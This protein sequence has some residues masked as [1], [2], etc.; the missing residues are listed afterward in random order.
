MNTLAMEDS[1]TNAGPATQSLSE[2][3]KTAVRPAIAAGCGAA[4]LMVVGFFGGAS[5][6][7]IAGA[8]VATGAISP[9]GRPQSVQHLDGG[10]VL[11]IRVRNG[12]SVTKDELL[13][14]LDD[15][16]LR[17]AVEIHR[18][19]LHEGLA[20]NARLSA[21]R[22]RAGAID[23]KPAAQFGD[24]EVPVA[25]R[26]SQER[27]F[28]IRRAARSGQSA[29]SGEK[30]KQFLNQKQ[31]V[32]GLLASKL[33]QAESIDLELAKLRRL[34]KEG[35]IAETRLLGLE[36]E[37][38]AL[39]GQV[40]EH[41]AELGRLENGIE[42]A[43]IA[44]LQSDREFQESVLSELRQ[45][46]A[47]VNDVAQQYR[48]TL[49]QLQRVEIRAPAAG[50]VHELA[51]VTVGGV[52]PARATV[53]QLVPQDQEFIVDANLDPQFVDQVVHG[54]SAIVRFPAFSRDTT[55]ELNG[56]VRTVSP[57]SI[58]DERTGVAFYRMEVQLPPAEFARLSG[59]SIVPGMPVEVFVQTGER[60]LVSYLLKP[61]TDQFQRALREK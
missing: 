22:D 35:F 21:E 44:L 33:Q 13:I 59:R 61:L 18:N 36:R 56:T 27:L 47:E 51:V 10:I 43:R 58:V 20:R 11:E 31:G 45:V 7:N 26:A 12:M 15:T 39:A 5:L 19:R 14:R 2:R 55:P 52:V 37:R 25:L 32:Q 9:S 48:A 23:W 60:S 28:E 30:V 3:P 17:A 49:E 54:Q 24:L 40:T 38:A 29:L 6:L 8:V 4:L 16:P 50:V 57:T 1:A 46:N 34:Q 53:M 42:E 41:R